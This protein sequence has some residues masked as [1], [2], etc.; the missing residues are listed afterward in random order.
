L[1]SPADG[2]VGHLLTF[3]ASGSYSPERGILT[4]QWNFGDG[5]TADFTFPRVTH[6]YHSEG[7]FDVQLTVKDDHGLADTVST[8]IKVL[9]RV[10]ATA[11]K[12]VYTF[13][14]NTTP[15][16]SIIKIM[17][18]PGSPGFMVKF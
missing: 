14:V 9:S 2:E 7:V 10:K 13:T 8:R 1:S 4:Y 3:D 18:I 12:D 6:R 16:D 17:N 11:K 15:I 5:I